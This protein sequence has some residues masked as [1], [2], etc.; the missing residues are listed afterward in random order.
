MAL[1]CVVL[2]TA[3]HGQVELRFDPADTTLA[4]GENCRMSIV[5]DDPLPA[6]RTIDVTVNY[7]AAVVRPLGGGAG[8]LYTAS[9]IYTF[10]GFEQ[11]AAGQWHGYAVLMGAGLSIH[12]PGELYYWNLEALLDGHSPVTAVEVY[13]STTDGSWFSTVLLPD[14]VVRVG[15]GASAVDGDG[16]LGEGSLVLAPNPFNPCTGVTFELPEAGWTTVTVHDLRG[17]LVASLFEGSAAAG[18]LAVEWDGRDDDG[19]PLPGGTYL[20]TVSAP[21]LRAEA[22]GVLLK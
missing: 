16:R 3:A 12:G 7:D 17:A 22:K 19:R 15:N 14:G 5:I 6:I 2:A 21:R 10:Q 20:F 13:V 18:P 9:G 11:P 8:T 1:W 4:V